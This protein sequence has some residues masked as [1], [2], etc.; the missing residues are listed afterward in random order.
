AFMAETAFEIAIHALQ[1]FGVHGYIRGGGLDQIVQDVRSTSLYEGTT[2]IQALDVL[3]RKVP[4]S[5]GQ[6]LQGL[7]RLI[8]D[9]SARHADNP[10]L[11][12]YCR[13]LV[14]HKNE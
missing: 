7:F 8:E 14:E 9:F 12:H 4:M 5:Q 6:A 3:G 1:C 11:A 2:G 13:S 10:A